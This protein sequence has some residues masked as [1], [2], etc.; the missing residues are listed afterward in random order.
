M[1]KKILKCNKL[2]EVLKYLDTIQQPNSFREFSDMKKDLEKRNF[3][4]DEFEL[5]IIMDKLCK[6]GYVST[7]A[8]Y[9]NSIESNKQ[10][11]FNET[12]ILNHRFYITF[13]GKIF[14]SKKLGGYVWQ[15]RNEFANSIFQIIS[16][17]LLAVGTVGLFLLEIWKNFFHC[18]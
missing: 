15:V 10:D 17:I 11:K 8:K 5:W 12:Q 3:D 14:I 4:Y 16:T 18:Y 7:E 1:D 2:D 6:D 13:D 9:I